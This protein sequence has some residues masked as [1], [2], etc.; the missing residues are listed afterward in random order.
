MGAAG[1]VG[2]SLTT[3]PW[4][5]EAMTTRRAFQS[6]AHWGAFTA[7]VEDGRLVGVSPFAEDP[8]P[9]PLIEAWPEMVYAENRIQKPSIRRGWLETVGGGLPWPRRRHL[10]RGLVG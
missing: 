6:L 5:G 4:K 10:R 2:R 7:H 9:S 1:D 3:D 8:Q